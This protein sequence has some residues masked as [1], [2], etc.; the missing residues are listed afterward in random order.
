MEMESISSF[1][2]CYLGFVFCIFYFLFV[3]LLPNDQPGMVAFAG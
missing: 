1:V 2:I 3:L